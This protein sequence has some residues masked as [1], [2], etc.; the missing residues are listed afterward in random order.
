MVKSQ[1]FKAHMEPPFL[2]LGLLMQPVFL[3]L[4]RTHSSS[5]WTTI[6]SILVNVDMLQRILSPL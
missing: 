4:V 3:K 6:T 5:T 2:G 1:V